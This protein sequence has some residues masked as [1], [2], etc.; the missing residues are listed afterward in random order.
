[1]RT[2]SGL[3]GSSARPMPTRLTRRT[4]ASTDRMLRALAQAQAGAEGGDGAA[5][6]AHFFVAGGTAE[7]REMPAFSACARGTSVA[8]FTA[9]AATRSTRRGTPME[10][11]AGNLVRGLRQKLGMTQEEFAHEI[12]VTVSTV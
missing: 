5:P 11:N 2:S 12:A 6:H 7:R 8:A 10:E 3:P 1:M 9:R 4:A